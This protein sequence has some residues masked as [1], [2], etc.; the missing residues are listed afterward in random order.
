MES[1]R[2]FER[3]WELKPS[4]TLSNSLKNPLKLSQTLSQTLSN[5]LKRKLNPAFCWFWGRL[6]L[7][8]HGNPSNFSE[9]QSMCPDFP[10]SSRSGVLI[11]CV[12]ANAIHPAT[13][14]TLQSSQAKVWLWVGDG[15]WSFWCWSWWWRG[16]VDLW[17]W[18]VL[19]D[20]QPVWVYNFFHWMIIWV[21]SG[22]FICAFYF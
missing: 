20:P 14:S 7:V 8:M 16:L 13:G 2:D 19:G 10:G 9:I 1:L 12:R 6:G 17:V 21:S 22:W 11:P 18:R 5:S 4:Q 3:F 15:R